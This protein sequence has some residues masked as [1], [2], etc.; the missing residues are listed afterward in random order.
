MKILVTGAQGCIGAWV[1]RGLLRRGLD[2]LIYDLDPNP[3]RLSLITEETERKN[4]SI[5][6]GVIEDTA[7]VKSI[8]KDEGVTH[9]IHLAAV[10]MPF[11]QAN[12][13]RGGLI[14]IIGTLNV[15]EGA[16]DS[17]R[18]VRVVYASSSAVWG[19]EDA[20]EA[21]ALSEADPTKP[22]THYGVFK[23]ANEGN[24]RAFYLANQI[25]SAG[26][27]PWTVYGVG[28]DVGLT[29]APTTA[30][31]HIVQGKPYQIPL[32]GFMDLQYVEDVAETFI[33]CALS[34]VAG[35]HVFNLA[36]DV[37]EMEELARTL[38]H[39]RPSA[40]NLITTG[41]PRVP[42]AYR[43]DDAALRAA[44]PGIPKTPL[45]DGMRRTIELYERL[46]AEG[47]LND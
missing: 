38:A 39:I 16:R 23:N 5:R 29:A 15:F 32:S 26:L 35:A 43:M 44:I 22:S 24:A 30:M 37:I 41:G 1:V 27:R 28:R 21:R 46:H 9:I 10:L 45:E 7:A 33:R 19:P 47:R 40:A 6:T 8:I 2:V 31:K 25:S 34:D 13:V 11:C 17:G 18:D 20:Y 4:L 36:G 14:N 3:A 12:P 42:V